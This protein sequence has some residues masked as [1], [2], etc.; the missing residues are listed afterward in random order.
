MLP[1]YVSSTLSFH[2]VSFLRL[3]RPTLP[4][5]FPPSLVPSFPHSLAPSFHTPLAACDVLAECEIGRSVDE[6]EH[7]RDAVVLEGR[8]GRGKGRGREGRREG[9]R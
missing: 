3:L 6:T 2:I 5:S 4:P 7:H 8:R 9:G 1:R